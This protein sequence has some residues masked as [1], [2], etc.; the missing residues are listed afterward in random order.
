MDNMSLKQAIERL[1]PTDEYAVILTHLTILRENL[2]AEFTNP[3]TGSN[4]MQLTN[5][6]GR[7]NMTDTILIEMGGPVYPKDVKQQ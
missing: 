1:R 3:E 5:L 6:A 7:I 2:L 4:P